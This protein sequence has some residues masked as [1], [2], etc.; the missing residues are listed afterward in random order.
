MSAKETISATMP[1]PTTVA[2]PAAVTKFHTMGK[3]IQ[4]EG[5]VV[6]WVMI[7][8][9]FAPSHLQHQLGII[10]HAIGYGESSPRFRC[11]HKRPK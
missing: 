3:A 8:L 1:K 9:H 11:L 6:S 7:V 5:E 4:E 2:K 10:L